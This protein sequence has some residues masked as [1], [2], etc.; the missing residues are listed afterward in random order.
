M[1]L[2]ELSQLYYLQ[3][4]VEQE[5]R[6]VRKLREKATKITARGNPSAGCFV[7]KTAIAADIADCETLM[8]AK[9]NEMVIIT[10]RLTAYIH[11]IDDSLTRQIFELRFI[12]GK[13]W[14]EVADECGGTESSVKKTCYRYLKKH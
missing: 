5:E 14:N 12:D 1:T 13:S 3:R 7:D 11:D 2:R 6:R 4:E 8:W 9:I 10:K